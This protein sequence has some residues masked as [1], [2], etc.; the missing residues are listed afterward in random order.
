MSVP[1]NHLIAHIRS[2]YASGLYLPVTLFLEYTVRV[3]G[4]DKFNDIISYK[5]LPE[6]QEDLYNNVSAIY[7]I[8]ALASTLKYYLASFAEND[9]KED[10]KELADG[11]QDHRKAVEQKAKKYLAEI[12]A[13][14]GSSFTFNDIKRRIATDEALVSLLDYPLN[15]EI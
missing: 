15:E 13:T 1:S 8:Q 3:G 12:N 9:M 2:L 5:L 14:H 7:D 4:Y 10:L 6:I 11:L